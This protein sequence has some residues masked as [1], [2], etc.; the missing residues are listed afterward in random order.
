M[1]L[2]SDRRQH[3]N[4]AISDLKNSFVGISVAV[5]VVDAMQP[6][7]GDLV[8]FVNASPGPPQLFSLV[9]SRSSRLRRLASDTS[10]P[11]YLALQS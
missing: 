9:F 3:G 1:L 8:H 6:F 2:P 4:L 11:P 5:P 7:D 10:S